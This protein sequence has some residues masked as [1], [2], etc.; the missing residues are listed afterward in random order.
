MYC[1]TT[2]GGRINYQTVTIATTVSPESAEV[3]DHP[4][5]KFGY[6]FYIDALSKQL[7]VFS[8]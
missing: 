5:E 6:S 1:P 4:S 2:K 8:K 3:T 7:G